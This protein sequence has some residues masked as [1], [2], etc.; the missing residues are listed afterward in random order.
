MIVKKTINAAETLGA[1]ALSGCSN[2]LSSEPRKNVVVTRGAN[3]IAVRSP[4][5]TQTKPTTNAETRP[6]TAPQAKYSSPSVTKANMPKPSAKGIA[7]AD[8]TRP[9]TMSPR[10][11]AELK[12]GIRTGSGG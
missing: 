7:T 5:P 4:R 3:T 11:D 6:A 10:K 8:E 2:E 1:G 12:T 9:P